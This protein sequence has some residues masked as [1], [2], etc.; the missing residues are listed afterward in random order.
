M[1]RLSEKK[2]GKKGQVMQI[3]ADGQTGQVIK[4]DYIV[5]N[6]RFFLDTIHT[7]HALLS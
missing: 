1:A 4:W 7:F 3:C 6:F 5:A 2:K